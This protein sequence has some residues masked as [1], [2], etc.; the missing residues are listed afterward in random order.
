MVLDE[1]EDLGANLLADF[2]LGV[3][4]RDRA[5]ADRL[6][7]LLLGRDQGA[8]RHLVLKGD[9]ALLVANLQPAWLYLDGATLKK[10][11]G[12]ERVVFGTDLYSYPVGKR[13]SHLLP[14]IVASSLDVAAKEAI[15]GGN[16]RRIL[17]L[18]A[19]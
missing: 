18:T 15:L 8:E 3:R 12:A 4:G 13:I 14:Q 7:G 19:P 6:F 9:L 11:F 2:F 16:A 10:Q 17:G 1:L 5:F